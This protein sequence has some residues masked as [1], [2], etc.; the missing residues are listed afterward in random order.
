MRPEPGLYEVYSSNGNPNKTDYPPKV[1]A[2]PQLDR[3]HQPLNGVKHVLG[4][5]NPMTDTNLVKGIW[6]PSR[7]PTWTIWC[8]LDRSRRDLTP[9]ALGLHEIRSKGRSQH[10]QSLW[11]FPSSHQGWLVD[12]GIPVRRLPSPYGPPRASP[13]HQGWFV[14]AGIPVRRLPPPYGPPRT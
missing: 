12:A 11:S 6:N 5:P 14:D 9:G 2:L 8:S 3:A 1:T 13:S 10:R 4:A 7:R